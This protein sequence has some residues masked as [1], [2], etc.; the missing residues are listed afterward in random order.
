LVLTFASLVPVL[1]KDVCIALLA[2][3]FIATG[4]VNNSNNPLYLC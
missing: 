2:F 4:G 1:T 3:S